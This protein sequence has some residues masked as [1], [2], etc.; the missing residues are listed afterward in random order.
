[1]ANDENVL[2]LVEK[3][4]RNR[5]T[6]VLTNRFRVFRSRDNAYAAADLSENRSKLYR[7]VVRRA[8]WGVE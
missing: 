3:V 4:S 5:I 7:Y 8:T 6:P 2:W 1:M